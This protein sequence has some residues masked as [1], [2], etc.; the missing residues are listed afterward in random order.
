M[1]TTSSDFSTLLNKKDPNT[2]LQ[3]KEIVR[4]GL[5][6]DKL[7]DARKLILHNAALSLNLPNGLVLYVKIVLDPESIGL[8]PLPASQKETNANINQVIAANVEKLRADLAAAQN[9]VDTKLGGRSKS[10]KELIYRLLR[11]AAIRKE[12]ERLT[13]ESGKE[14]KTFLEKI[15]H[16]ANPKNPPQ[17]EIQKDIEA[18]LDT[19]IA[20]TGLTYTSEQKQGAVNLVVAAT[21][22]EVENLADQTSRSEVLQVALSAHPDYHTPTSDLFRQIDENTSY[23]PAPNYRDTVNRQIAD[24]LAVNLTKVT[25]PSGEIK[26]TEVVFPISGPLQDRLEKTQDLIVDFSEKILTNKE[27]DLVMADLT[28]AITPDQEKEFNRLL[29]AADLTDR[30]AATQA[31]ATAATVI[32]KL[33]PTSPLAPVLRWRSMGADPAAI[34][35]HIQTIP[36][37]KLSAFVH[38]NPTVLLHFQRQ[39][40]QLNLP[41]NQL[42]RET[43]APPRLGPLAGLTNGFQSITNR[44]SGFLPGQVGQVFNAATHPFQFIQGKIGNFIGNQFVDKFKGWLVEK[45]GAKIANESFNRAAQ[46]VLKEGLTKGIEK[47]ASFAIAKIG[48]T[49]LVAGISAAIGISTLGVGTVIQVAVMA[50]IE[51]AKFGGKVVMGILNG[52]SRALTGEDF[53]WKPIAATPLLLLGGIGGILGSLGAA[54]SVAA[55][56]AGVALVISA[57]VGFFLYITV[58]TVAPIITTIAQLDSGLGPQ[59]GP[60]FGG[61]YEP[62]TGPILPGCS[63]IWPVSGG[64]VLQGPH[65]TYSHLTAEAVDIYVPIGTP[66]KSM[67]SGMVALTGWGDSYG[68]WIQVRSTSA[69]GKSY[70]VIYAHLSEIGVQ[71]GNPV[72]VGT[73]IALS[74][75]S[76]SVPSFANPHLH[77]EYRGIAYNSCPA[78]GVQVPDGCAG[79]VVGKPNACLINGK[80]IYTK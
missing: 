40:Q 75:A 25:L 9:E 11:V 4:S 43:T 5:G 15:A 27:T 69:N 71:V 56:S 78:G 1:A 53:D 6:F 38:N 63:Q 72:G 36:A 12:A 8:P 57:L 34:Q 16:E 28:G 20:I 59:Q 58:I 35:K 23:T 60:A 24:D 55:M 2:V 42:G 68:N 18:L 66:V 33:N 22:A 52:L 17:P 44:L 31:A 74:G 46:F 77:M 41:A 64:L 65:G 21:L 70:T 79:A 37:S 14:Q 19:A 47:V 7:S 50:G 73:V 29:I 54:T 61:V 39:T 51:V 62:Y 32:G 10:D 3:L 13:A 80:P 30:I 48:G 49:A 45:V 67:S 76:S 26:A